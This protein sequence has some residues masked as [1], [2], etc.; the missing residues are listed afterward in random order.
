MAQPPDP[1]SLG[2]N[3]ETARLQV[4]TEFFNPP[5]PIVTTNMVPTTAG[6]LEDDD[7]NFGAMAMG[8]GK[9]FLLGTNSSPVGV[10]KQWLLVNNQQFLVEEVP[11]RFITNRLSQLPAP[12]TA[13]I[14]NNPPLDVVSARRLLPMRPS[15]AA[16][17]KSHMHL[18]KSS[19][20]DRG[21]VLDYQIL[22]SRQT[23]Y[24]FQGDTTYLI[25]APVYLYGT[26]IFEGG[27]V[28]KYTNNASMGLQSSVAS[29]QWPGSPYRPVIFTSM[30]DNTV[31]ESVPGSTGNPTN[32]Y[33]TALSLAG[34]TSIQNVR[35]LHAQY[36]I[37][38][39]GTLS[40][41]MCRWSTAKTACC[42][43]TA[44]SR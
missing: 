41:T 28:I 20:S 17:D 30:N 18:A 14:Q 15:V 21:L 6:N 10:V 5:Q 24:T 1:A 9:A 16:H 8:R 37:G 3:P 38:A 32:Y 7:L 22:N 23:N 43:I 33:P 25:S 40:V 27:A 2:L 42:S 34:N 36:T 29:R 44:I 35:I 12:Q 4:F 31:G 39:Y 26:N 13:S 19:L 11:F